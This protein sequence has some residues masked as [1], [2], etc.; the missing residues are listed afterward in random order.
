MDG[1]AQ[2][3]GI[4]LTDKLLNSMSPLVQMVISNGGESQILIQLKPMRELTL[5]SYK[6]ERS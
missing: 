5:H 3:S 4:A 1:L 6:L 2:V